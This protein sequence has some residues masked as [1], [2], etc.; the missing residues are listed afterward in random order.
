MLTVA[1]P[2]LAAAPKEPKS[3]KRRDSGFKMITSYNLFCEHRRPEVRA[4]NPDIVP[5][6]DNTSFLPV[7]YAAA[8]MPRLALAASPCQEQSRIPHTADHL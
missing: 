8:A 4:A 6:C 1:A 2:V 3:H 7:A 5:R